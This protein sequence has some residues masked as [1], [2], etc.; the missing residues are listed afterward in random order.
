MKFSSEQL[1]VLKAS[2]SD[3]SLAD[4]LALNIGQI[5]ENMSLRRAVAL[6][7][8]DANTK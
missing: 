6:Y 2:G 7:A 1:G 8:L 5:G 3:K 4:V